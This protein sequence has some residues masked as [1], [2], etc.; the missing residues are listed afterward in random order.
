MIIER[1]ITSFL[2]SSQLDT[3]WLKV[4]FILTII[5]GSIIKGNY[6]INYKDK[7]SIALSLILF[8]GTFLSILY[9]FNHNLSSDDI[10]TQLYR[11]RFHFIEIVFAI[12]LYFRL[13]KKSYNEIINLILLGLSMNIVVGLFQFF[14]GEERISLLFFEPSAAGLF[15]V[16]MIPL[17]LGI[18]NKKKKY[19]GYLFLIIG[20]FIIS[21]SQI[22]I[23]PVI[24]FLQ[25]T[26][27]Q[28]VI[29]LFLIP[30]VIFSLYFYN[31]EQIASISHVGKVLLNEGIRGLNETN[32]IWTSWT[33]RISSAY[34]SILLLFKYPLGI[35]FGSFNFEY[36][37]EMYN[38]GLFQSI[39]GTEISR[40]LGGY[41]FNTPKSIILEIFVSCGIFG[42]IIYFFIFK[43]FWRI[44]KSNPPIFY[45]FIALT[46]SGLTVELAPI[47][48]FIIIL[49]A[50][51][52]K[53]D[54]ASEISKSN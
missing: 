39:S 41:I 28:K 44:R 10:N 15:Y 19:I 30:V 12:F 14:S 6:S 17:C 50:L 49:V 51:K 53:I 1:L 27:K 23:A 31:T 8:I 25:A 24:L 2:M 26:K 33:Y 7:I 3:A 18:F 36:A 42:I 34:T 37:K 32:H 29:L 22:I 21:K 47:F 52:L 4:L 16:F 5:I 45:S 35:G 11:I 46:L 9:I 13:K 38:S 43:S 54:E 40:A 48:T 20:I